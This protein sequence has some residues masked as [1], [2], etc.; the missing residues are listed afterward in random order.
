MSTAFTWGIPDINASV[1]KQTPSD[2]KVEQKT[3]GNTGLL[4]DWI[5]Y[6]SIAIPKSTVHKLNRTINERAGYNGIL[7]ETLHRELV[8]RNSPG[9]VLR[10]SVGKDR[11]ASRSPSCI[12]TI[13]SMHASTAMIY[14]DMALDRR[15]RLVAHML[16]RYKRSHRTMWKYW[17]VRYRDRAKF[18][19]RSPRI[20]DTKAEG[21]ENIMV[22][23]DTKKFFSQQN[24]E[25]TS[26]T[27][28]SV[29]VACRM[30]T[31]MCNVAYW[32]KP[33]RKVDIGRHKTSSQAEQS[34]Y[35]SMS[36]PST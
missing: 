32:L 26:G 7:V 5:H 23:F 22:P 4:S 17:H 3:A 9:R 15:N 11:L 1:D 24:S 6:R 14:W 19:T 12:I 28:P 20:W 29:R 13:V 25:I 27:S 2:S 10:N 33:N 21:T 30:S 35:R 36:Y 34:C 16:V 31:E 8:T 18:V